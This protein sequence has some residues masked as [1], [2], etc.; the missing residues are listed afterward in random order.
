[1]K[2]QILIKYALLYFCVLILSTSCKRGINIDAIEAMGKGAAK[3]SA[4]LYYY[5]G[6]KPGDRV[7]IEKSTRPEYDAM[8]DANL[9]LYL[10]TSPEIKRDKN[11]KVLNQVCQVFRGDTLQ[12]VGEYNQSEWNKEFM[13]KQNY[14][15]F[16]KVRAVK[17]GKIAGEGWFYAN[18]LLPLQHNWAVVFY[19]PVD[20]LAVLFIFGSLILVVYLLWKLIY[21]L[22]ED[23]IRKKDCFWQDEKIYFK[24]AYLIMST[25]VGLM[26]FYVDYNDE[27]VNSLKFNPNFF[28]HFSE[29][30]FLLKLLPAIALLWVVSTV[31]MLWEMI[32]KFHTLWLII[33]FPGIWSI[34]FL[35]VAL[36]FAV[37]WLIY[38]ILPMVVGFVIM[39]FASKADD[40]T[41]GLISKGGGGSKKRHGGFVGYNVKGEE[42]GD[43][44][45][46]NYPNVTKIP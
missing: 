36:V 13:Q 9:P 17:N 1:M 32:K 14:S 19:Q 3:D 6:L 39:M 46:K 24:A 8:Q 16:V 44:D 38:L 30:P 34:G 22:I 7:R 5:L 35:L 29:Y 45:R 15:R 41:G 2:R 28:A 10:T 37:S 12:V 26:V 42:I 4:M 31:G 18:G 43:F 11:L 23:K 20:V 27:L 21:W 40:A 25:L 33:Y